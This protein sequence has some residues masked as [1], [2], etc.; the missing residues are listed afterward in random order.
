MAYNKNNG[1][2][3]SRAAPGLQNQHAVRGPPVVQHAFPTP[4]PLPR[5]SNLNAGVP[6]TPHRPL[7][8]PQPLRAPLQPME[9]N[10]SPN[11]MDFPRQASSHA[12]QLTP[13]FVR[14]PPLSGV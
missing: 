11:Y 8:L 7:P 12:T 5:A 3:G 10:S 4:Q 1:T 2:T 13:A 9:A 14:G 6:Q